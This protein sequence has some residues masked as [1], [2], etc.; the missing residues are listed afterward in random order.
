[1]LEHPIRVAL[2]KPTAAAVFLMV[3]G[4]ILLGAERLRRRA[5]VRGAGARAT[6]ARPDAG[7]HRR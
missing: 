2:A 3:N 4:L 1:M 5:E 7:G 6:G